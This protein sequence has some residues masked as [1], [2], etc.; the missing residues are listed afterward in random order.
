MKLSIACIASHS[1]LDVFDG[2]KD[3][4]F[5]TIAICRKGRER[6]YAAA[7]ETVD[8]CIVLDSYRNVIS[9]QIQEKLLEEGSII[10]PN[11]S[12]A[13]Y[14]GYDE[15]EKE[16]RVPVFGNK[17][18]LRWEERRGEKNY[19][20]LLD[21][22]GIRHPSVWKIDEVSGPALLKVQE[23]GRPQERAFIFASGRD[24][25]YAKIDEA[26]KRG[27]I[28]EEQ[29]ERSVAEELI[30]GAHFNINYFYSVARQRLEILSVDRR[31]Q[32]NLD[33]ILHL[34]AQQQLEISPRISMVEVGHIPVTLR[35]SLLEEAYSIGE[36]F[37]EATR[38]VE[39]PGIIGPFTLQTIVTP[40]LQ[41]VVYDVAPRIGGG[42][43][44]HMAIGGQY[45]KLFL[46]KP[47]S[48]GR[49]IAIEIREMGREERVGEI[50]T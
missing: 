13:V 3:E 8:K 41:L 48:L 23:A 2:A 11:R 16:L 49:R 18:M 7:K 26:L 33:G 1:A 5:P 6:I 15:I 25:L 50:T 34:P 28:S 39:P 35:E 37:V 19:Y 31:I 42:T 9:P 32:S 24:D 27:I 29:L 30:I 40:E 44:A 47:V 45:S 12:M 46:R 14:V 38:R 21:E 36:R 17:R 20:R 4:G 43:N 22:A 10:V